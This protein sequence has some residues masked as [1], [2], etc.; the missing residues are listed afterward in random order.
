LRSG[1]EFKYYSA[2]LV[3]NNQRFWQPILKDIKV[4]KKR[5]TELSYGLGIGG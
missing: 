3:V 1:A 5:F 2:Y 4:V